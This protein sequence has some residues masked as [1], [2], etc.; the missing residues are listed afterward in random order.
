MRKAKSMLTS[1]IDPTDNDLKLRVLRHIKKLHHKESTRKMAQDIFNYI[2][3][4]WPE[5][6]FDCWGTDVYWDSRNY[7]KK[8]DLDA[9]IRYLERGKNGR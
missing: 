3:I 1:E 2:V 9:V 6:S 8:Y 7:N 5:S 4:L